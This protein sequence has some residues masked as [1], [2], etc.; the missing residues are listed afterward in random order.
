MSAAEP[1]RRRIHVH[2][3]HPEVA[4]DPIHDIVPVQQPKLQIVEERIVR[5]PQAFLMDEPLTNLD[6]K[7]R[8]ELRVELVRLQRD[9]GVPTVFVTHD[10]VEALSMGDRIIVLS[11]GRILQSGTAEEV[12]RRPASPEVARQLGSPPINLI[13]VRHEDGHWVARGGT[14]VMR[15]EDVAGGCGGN[16]TILGVR[17]EDVALEGGA[18]K[19]VVK[20]VEDM[21]PNRIILVHWAGRDIHVTTTRG[22]Q[23]KPG[24]EVWP[25]IDPAKTVMWPVTSR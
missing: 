3:P 22:A 17:P 9:L 11:G 21:G 24:D 16:E 1:D 13:T 10:Q 8:E 14:P 4:L 2:V 7:L 18:H 20:I 23:A 25:L 15:C 19:G 12:Y 5:R 6:A